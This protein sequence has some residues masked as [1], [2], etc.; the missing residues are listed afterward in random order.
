MAQV[1]LTEAAN[2]GFLLL[3]QRSYTPDLLSF[4]IYYFL[5]ILFIIY[6][7]RVFHISISW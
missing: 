3:P 6:S 2:Y 4:L 1:A 7:S 5:G